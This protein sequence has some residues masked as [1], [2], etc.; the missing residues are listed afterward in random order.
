MGSLTV[1]RSVSHF[2]PIWQ[3]ASAAAVLVLHIGLFQM[4]ETSRGLLAMPLLVALVDALK[5]YQPNTALY[6]PLVEPVPPE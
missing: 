1:A 6:L 4:G 2:G 3:T 5:T